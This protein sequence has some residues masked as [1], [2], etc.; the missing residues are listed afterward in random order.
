[1][2]NT[3]PINDFLKTIDAAINYFDPEG[4]NTE[5]GRKFLEIANETVK[6]ETDRLN[7]AITEVKTKI[8]A[9]ELKN[10]VLSG[11]LAFTVQ[12]IS[13]LEKDNLEKIERVKCLKEIVEER[14]KYLEEAQMELDSHRRK[15]AFCDI[16]EKRSCFEKD[17]WEKSFR[18]DRVRIECEKKEEKL[19]KALI[20]LQRLHENLRN[21][22]EQIQKARFRLGIE[23]NDRG[24]HN[25]KTVEESDKRTPVRRPTTAVVRSKIFAK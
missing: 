23:K 1:M 20:K 10:T 12:E 18:N 14:K 13:A 25:L 17:V 21:V 9:I 24:V 6:I 8:S 22:K 2:I 4:K 16:A 19:E 5:E 11:N 7:K 15:E 3:Q